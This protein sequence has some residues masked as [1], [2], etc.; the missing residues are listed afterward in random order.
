[1]R[2]DAYVNALGSVLKT[3]PVNDELSTIVSGMLLDA[4]TIMATL[5]QVTTDKNGDEYLVLA[6]EMDAVLQKRILHQAVTGADP[7]FTLCPSALTSWRIPLQSYETNTGKEAPQFHFNGDE[8]RLSG[9]RHGTEKD[10]HMDDTIFDFTEDHELIAF[11]Q[12]SN[13][14]I[15]ALEQFTNPMNANGFAASVTKCPRQ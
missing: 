10:S 9:Y 7:T 14:R 5:R 6:L 1:M 8:T 15:N 2:R 13:V 11:R 12:K 3:R 4:H